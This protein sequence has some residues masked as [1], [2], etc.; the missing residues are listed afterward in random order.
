M[1]THSYI[2]RDG[3]V[4]PTRPH[5]TKLYTAFEDHY[6]SDFYFGGE[7]HDFW[8]LVVNSIG[9]GQRKEPRPR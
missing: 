8:E 5:I 3:C 4:V 6:D 9:S 2:P 1:P 7:V